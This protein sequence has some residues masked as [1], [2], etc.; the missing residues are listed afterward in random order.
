MSRPGQGRSTFSTGDAT[1]FQAWLKEQ[2][3]FHEWSYSRLAEELDMSKGSITRWLTDPEDE[4]YRRPSYETVKR[5]S[6]IFGVDFDVLKEYAGLEESQSTNLTPLQREVAAIVVTMP[7]ALLT[8]I[9]PQLRAL[10]SEDRQT[11]VL[12]RMRQSLGTDA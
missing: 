10:A 11:K 4:N 7:D 2:M 12:A 6:K 5:L 3:E 8:V 1:R 9:L